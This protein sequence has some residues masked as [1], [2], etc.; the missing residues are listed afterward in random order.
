MLLTIEKVLVLK[1]VSISS[2]TPEDIL[3]DVT[4]VLDEVEVKAGE[5][6]LTKGDMGN[7]MY[8]V[9]E[10]QVRVHDGER[11]LNF[12][13]A[14]EVFGEMAVL[15]SA[16]RVASVTATE[17]TQLLRLDQA[18]FYELMENRIEIVRGILQ[19]FSGYVRDRVQDVA[20]LDA[21]L[22]QLQQ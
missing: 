3:V 5:S 22:Q 10:G 14:R 6:I 11:T 19:V 2:T 16:P 20:A 17:D 21:Q 8:I 4:T 13:G 1:S 7:S 15:D 12:L 18:P 9:V